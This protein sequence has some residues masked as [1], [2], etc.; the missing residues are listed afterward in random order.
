MH[1]DIV[2]SIPPE[3]KLQIIAYNEICKNQGM[4]KENHILTLQG[5]PEYVPTIILNFMD[6]RRH[7]MGER[8]YYDGMSKLLK[9][10]DTDIFVNVIID[11][12]Q[13]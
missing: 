12:F 11:F 8:L 5:H 3:S 6:D 13:N 1:Q 10:Q 4:V 2:E 7:I 9:K